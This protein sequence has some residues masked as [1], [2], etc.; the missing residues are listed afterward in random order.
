MRVRRGSRQEEAP[1]V[2]KEHETK[3]G[4]GPSGEEWAGRV[5]AS[6]SEGE[7]A[8]G[9]QGKTYRNEKKERRFKHPYRN[10]SALW[11]WFSQWILD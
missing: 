7:P 2:N 11:P 1:E 4:C 5:S 6:K 8:G 3:Q 10:S 9:V